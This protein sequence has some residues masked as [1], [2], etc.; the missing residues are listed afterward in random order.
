MTTLRRF[1]PALLLA[2]SCASPDEHMRPRLRAAELELQATVERLAAVEELLWLTRSELTTL[3][4]ELDDVRALILVGGPPR[5]WRGG[6][7]GCD[8]ARYL[9]GSFGEAAHRALKATGYCDPAELP[10]HLVSQ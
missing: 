8:G 9:P 10:T 5:R 6:G 4:S 1:L 3:S 7:V 2:L